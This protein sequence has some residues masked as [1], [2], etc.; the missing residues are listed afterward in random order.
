M[1]GKV[2]IRWYPHVFENNALAKQYNA[3]Y[4]REII[5]YGNNIYL[6]KIP[7]I[8]SL[9]HLSRYADCSYQQLFS[10]VNRTI[11]PYQS[12][13]ITKRTG[14]FRQIVVPNYCLMKTQRWINHN[15]LSKGQVHASVYAYVKSGNIK[16]NAELHCGAKWLIKMDIHRFFESIT[17]RQVYRVFQ[18]FGYTKLL[19]FELTRLCT[20]VTS[21]N[22]KIKSKR[23]LVR[24]DKYKYYRSY[25]QGYLPQG[26]P[27]SPTLSN[28]VFFKIDQQILEIAKKYGCIYSRYSDDLTFSTN[29]FDRGKAKQLISEI[30]ILLSKNGFRRNHKKTK[31]I[32]PGAK[33]IITGLIVNSDEPKVGKELKNRIEN[34][35]YFSIKYGVLSHCERIKFKSIEGFKNH[36]LGLIHYVSSIDKNLGQKYKE[37]FEKI[38]WSIF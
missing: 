11:N 16:R 29:N 33:K 27:T 25:I 37:E 38:D 24:G 34:H 18:D 32:P 9:A 12:F 13:K 14:G 35:L 36:L 20:R 4:I 17:E 21:N 1:R 6:K 3:S 26:S 19:S 30:S 8:F 2:M 5:K 23:W 10:I 31:I 15:I 22:R 28:L 7:I